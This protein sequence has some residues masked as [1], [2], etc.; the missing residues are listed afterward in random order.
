[1]GKPLDPQHVAIIMDGNGRWAERRGLP[2]GF[3]HRAGVEALRRIARHS[4]A[5]GIRY[6]TVYAFSTENWKRPRGEVNLLI[7][8]LREYFQKTIAELHEMRVR[9]RVLGE[10]APF[11]SDVRRL[12]ESA[13]ELTGLNDG[14]RLQIALNYGGRAEILRA[15]QNLA[16][17]ALRGAIDPAEIDEDC[18]A[19][20]LDTAG[21]PDPEVII[22]TSGESRLSNFLLWQAAY[23]EFV[24][25]E[26]CW[27]DFDEKSLENALA[28]YRRRERRFGAVRRK[29]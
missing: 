8:L 4:A 16:G 20:H 22:R 6:L 1:M 29:K 13:R 2:R 10:M 15:A 3:G 19:R 23:A 25:V 9:V 7:G 11:P 18:L 26:E 14:L 12:A 17:Q 24:V 27:P 28:E 21:L 5:L